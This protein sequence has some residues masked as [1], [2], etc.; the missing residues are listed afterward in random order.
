MKETAEH[1]R[2]HEFEADSLAFLKKR[3][4]EGT[5]LDLSRR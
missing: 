1:H 5:D 2:K 3:E 4:I